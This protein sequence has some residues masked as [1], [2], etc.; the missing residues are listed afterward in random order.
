MYAIRIA[1]VVSFGVTAL[2]QSGVG[3]PGNSTGGGAPGVRF[4]AR[5]DPPSPGPWARNFSIGYEAKIVDSYYVAHRYLYDDTHDVFLG[6]DLL[7]QSQPQADTF[8][9]SF[10]ELGIGA[11]ELPSL[12]G[13]PRAQDPG[14]WTKLPLDKYPSRQLIHVGDVITVD[15][16]TAPDT[17]QKIKDEIR[18]DAILVDA[19]A[20]T[21]TP[22]GSSVPARVVVPARAA[23]GRGLAFTP[24]TVAGRVRGFSVEDAEMRIGPFRI[25]VDGIVET[26][27]KIA[28]AS[29]GALVWFS[30]PNRGRYVLSLLPHPT[31][32]F[33]EAGEVRGGVA[34]FTLAGTTIKLECPAAIAPGYAA[35][36]LYVMHDPQ[37]EPTAQSQRRDIQYG[38][39]DIE[40]L[41]KL[42]QN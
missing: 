34:L 12:A 14:E 30:L 31:L 1:F 10:L 15:V 29:T 33:T 4:S 38:S 20:G 7:I 2:A 24:P 36:N 19:I 11:L 6:Y 26:P 22:Q 42:M 3:I 40:E 28:T 37:W 17:K 8:L 39:V 18:I 13:H 23:T 41:A 25:S 21:I 5:V 16:W 35:Y 27:P 32:G 9:A